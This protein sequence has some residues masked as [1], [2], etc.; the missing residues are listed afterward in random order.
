MDVQSAKGAQ[1]QRIEDRLINR[2]LASGGSFTS[3]RPVIAVRPAVRPFPMQPAPAR[4]PDPNKQ[5]P[6]AANFFPV[7]F[8]GDLR[9]TA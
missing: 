8:R 6:D 2:P 3:G 7:P 4:F 5:I 9:T 1:M